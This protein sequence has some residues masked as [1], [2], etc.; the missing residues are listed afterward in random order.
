MKF[1]SL[2]LFSLYISYFTHAQISI[3]EPGAIK[4]TDFDKGTW[5]EMRNGTT[6]F[7]YRDA[8]VPKLDMIKGILGEIWT[9]NKWKLIPYSEYQNSISEKGN[10]YIALRSYNKTKVY[11]G[12][13][14]SGNKAEV[15]EVLI[16]M[17]RV[18]KVEKDGWIAEER[19]AAIDM[20]ISNDLR[21]QLIQL[22]RMP[23]F[24]FISGNE[25]KVELWNWGLLKNKFQ[26][27][28]N[29]LVSNTPRWRFS[30]T[31]NVPEL[32]RLKSDTLFIPEST[33]KT[34]DVREKGKTMDEYAGRYKVISIEELGDRILKSEKPFYYLN[35]HMDG[36]EK[37]IN[38]INSK[39][40]EIVYSSYK[41][42]AYYFNAK[43]VAD[44]VK[45]MNKKS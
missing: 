44:L 25:A 8:D 37:F 10:V 9:F 30:N 12:P 21:T 32:N 22:K 16:S 15:V 35:V 34:F 26:V 41:G 38:V 14:P 36:L 6:C 18:D 24:E 45:Y 28:N 40:G 39:T 17:W 31:Q 29:H 7:I 5:E 3:G 4:P 42:A 1:I 23:A 33:F 43:D 2:L 11:A 27:L 13:D 19:L 20:P